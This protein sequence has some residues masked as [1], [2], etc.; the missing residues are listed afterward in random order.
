L[1]GLWTVDGAGQDVIA[2]FLTTMIF[3]CS[4]GTEFSLCSGLSRIGA[5]RPPLF[6]FVIEGQYAPHWYSSSRIVIISY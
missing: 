6:E 3:D 1:H 5:L 4:S 2:V